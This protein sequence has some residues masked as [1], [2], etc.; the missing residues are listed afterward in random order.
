MAD[1]T[2]GTPIVGAVGDVGASEGTIEHGTV[3][4]RGQREGESS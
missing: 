3:I 1:R 2:L 4:G